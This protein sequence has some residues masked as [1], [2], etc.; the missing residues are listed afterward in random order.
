MLRDKNTAWPK[1]E[2]VISSLNDKI[3]ILKE[4]RINR[5]RLK[6]GELDK[7]SFE[8]RESELTDKWIK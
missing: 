7:A 1:L 5:D 3:E 2:D 8:R 6:T 4:K